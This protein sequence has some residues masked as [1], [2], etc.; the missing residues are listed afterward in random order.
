LIW[1]ESIRHQDKAAA[2]PVMISSES[3]KKVGN[4]FSKTVFH[5]RACRRKTG[6]T[7]L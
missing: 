7:V 2:I 5:F 4:G 1:P 6:K 3:T